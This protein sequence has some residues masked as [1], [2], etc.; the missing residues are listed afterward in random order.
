MAS[1]ERNRGF[2]VTLFGLTILV[3]AVILWYFL[4][5]DQSN[6]NS[7]VQKNDTAEINLVQLVKVKEDT[8]IQ[9]LKK[10]YEMRNIPESVAKPSNDKFLVL[11]KRFSGNPVEFY[12]NP[13]L[14]SNTTQ[15]FSIKVTPAGD[16]EASF[17]R[18]RYSVDYFVEVP[19]DILFRL[20]KGRNNQ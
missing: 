7:Q 12:N 3:V 15:G 18:I 19:S 6:R 5:K 8:L 20:L 10:F 1:E 9:L 13:K 16:I 14:T 17:K 4:Q 2:R 11:V